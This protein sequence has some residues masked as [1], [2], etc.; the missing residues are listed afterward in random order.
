[1]WNENPKELGPTSCINVKDQGIRTVDGGTHIMKREE[2]GSDGMG[3]TKRLRGGW[4][5]VGKRKSGEW[6]TEKKHFEIDL[7]G[8]QY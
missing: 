6:K 4:I 8:Q 3:G 5:D 7:G 2:N 1:M